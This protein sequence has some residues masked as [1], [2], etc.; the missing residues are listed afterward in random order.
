MFMCDPLK[1]IIVQAFGR[2]KEFPARDVP[3][4]F[5]SIPTHESRKGMQEIF[6]CLQTAFQGNIDREMQLAAFRLNKVRLAAALALAATLAFS[7]PRAPLV[8]QQATGAGA[9]SGPP[10]EAA[11]SRYP[12]HSAAS[13]ASTP[14]DPSG[15]PAAPKTSLSDLA[16]LA[17]RW[18][19]TWGPRIVQQEWMPPKAGVMLGTFQLVENDETLVIELYTMVEKASGIELYLRHFTAKLA[20]WEK[21]APTVL[22]LASANPNVVVFEN[23]VNGQPRRSIFRRVDADTYVSRSEIVPDKGDTQVVEITYHRQKAVAPPRH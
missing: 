4:A 15:P 14:A 17:G 3:E 20:P 10:H 5:I 6:H 2:V 22:N 7:S 18:Q 13:A 11:A 1:L 8:A 9:T 19:G 16:W 21:S 23:A 12:A